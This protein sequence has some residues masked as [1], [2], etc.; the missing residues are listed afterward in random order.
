MSDT[1]VAVKQKPGDISVEKKLSTNI[2]ITDLTSKYQQKVNNYNTMIGL[3]SD[4]QKKIFQTAINIYDIKQRQQHADSY[5]GYALAAL[6]ASGWYY[7]VDNNQWLQCQTIDTIDV[8]PTPEEIAHNVPIDE[9]RHMRYRRYLDTLYPRESLNMLG[10]SRWEVFDPIMDGL[11]NTEELNK[12]V[13]GE[14]SFENYDLEFSLEYEMG[15]EVTKGKK[16]SVNKIK[17]PDIPISPNVDVTELTKGD[18][19]ADKFIYAYTDSGVSKNK[20]DWR[21]M[22]MDRIAQQV[23]DQCP[24][25]NM[26]HMK[27][28]DVGYSLPL[29]VITWIGAVTELLPNGSKRLWVK[30]YVIPTSDGNNLKTYIR[31]KAINSISVFGGLT[32]LPNAETGVQD[33]LDIE[34]KSIDI[35]GKLNEGLNSGITELAGEMHTIGANENDEESDMSGEQIQMLNYM[36]RNK[37]NKEESEEQTMANNLFDLKTITLSDLK[38][39]NP[40]LYGE[41]QTEII[42]NMQTENEQKVI[43]TKAGEMDSLTVQ[44]G[45][46]PTEVFQRYQTF[47]GEMAEAVGIVPVANNPVATIEAITNKVK[48]MA[49]SLANVITILKPADNQTVE[50]KAE[51]VAKENQL[52]V[53][54]K[55]VEEANNKFNDLTKDITNEAVKNLVAMQ[56]NS[57][58]NAKPEELSDTYATDSIATLEAQVPEAVKNVTANAQSLLQNGQA[59]G[60]MLAFQNIGVGAGARAGQKSAKDMSDI[61]YAQSL[62]YSFS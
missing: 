14:M 5:I 47:A 31:A 51:E 25:G 32:L 50:A 45:G 44:M 6:L 39:G 56:F 35:S 60:E 52:A 34:L 43:L 59:A 46:N 4:E 20:R 57:I 11:L 23:M 8:Q 26:G 2:T 36:M 10:I 24:P 49:A 61:E 58:L 16:S 38:I 29:P 42:A 54:T 9:I 3:M 30:G 37:T 62:G 28:Q 7:N 48:E 1:V 33:V 55:A 27:P 18:N 41:M 13:S 40:K 12:A 22:I 19:S 53:N 17:H 21:P 15:G